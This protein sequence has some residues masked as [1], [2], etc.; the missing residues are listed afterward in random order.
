ME[1]VQIFGELVQFLFCIPRVDKK[2][3]IRIRRATG[4]GGILKRNGMSSPKIPPASVDYP[5]S[6][7]TNIH[8]AFKFLS[9]IK[10]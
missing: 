6:P 2:P 1:T 4:K 9:D 10:I 8:L 7:A 5:N 3:S